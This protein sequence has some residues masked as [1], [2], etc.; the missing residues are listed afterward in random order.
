VLT[1][2]IASHPKEAALIMYACVCLHN[3]MVA[4]VSTYTNSEH[5]MDPPK[6]QRRT[7]LD[8]V[9]RT[10]T[11]KYTDEAANVRERLVQYFN[12]EGILDWQY[13]RIAKGLY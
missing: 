12:N 13:D 9:E 8:D 11:N 10:S 7:E 4:K 3:W 6:R 5:P 2:P 1:T